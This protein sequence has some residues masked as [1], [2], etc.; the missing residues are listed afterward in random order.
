MLPESAAPASEDDS[1]VR[2]KAE[3]SDAASVAAHNILMA[4]DGDL[5][6]PG[7]L[8]PPSDTPAAA[9]VTA[10]GAVSA[11]ESDHLAAGVT[12]PKG[13]ALAEEGEPGQR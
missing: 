11:R 6:V 4:G 8:D 7:R 12:P 10:E 13:A 1:R 3:P 9:K 5:T 2:G